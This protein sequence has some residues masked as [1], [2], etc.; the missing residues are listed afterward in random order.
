M[1]RWRMPSQAIAQPSVPQ[2]RSKNTCASYFT[3]QNDVAKMSV[4]LFHR[5][6]RRDTV[7][8]NMLSHRMDVFKKPDNSSMTG[9]SIPVTQ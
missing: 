1:L 7:F 8:G 4:V 3:V 6:V 2:P 9:V 5:C